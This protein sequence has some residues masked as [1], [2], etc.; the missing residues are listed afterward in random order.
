[1]S[2]GSLLIARAILQRR[3][4]EVTEEINTLV[5]FPVRPAFWASSG[6]EVIVDYPLATGNAPGRINPGCRGRR[7]EKRSRTAADLSLYT[8]WTVARRLSRVR[9]EVS[10]GLFFIPPGGQVSGWRTVRL[11]STAP[12]TKL[13]QCVREPYY[14]KRRY[15]RA[16]WPQRGAR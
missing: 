11:I 4:L 15:W 16:V 3:F 12:L 8:D 1:M 2:S 13:E 10:S 5:P 7:L 6:D 14:R 9:G